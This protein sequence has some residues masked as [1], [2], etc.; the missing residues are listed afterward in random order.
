MIQQEKLLER[1]KTLPN[2]L[3]IVGQKYSGKKT[4]LKE[5]APDFYW[6][7]GKVDAIRTLLDGDYVFADVDD[8]SPACFS[9][10]LKMLEE[11]TDHI[12]ITCK[13][14]MNLPRSIQSR[15]IIERMEPYT[16]LGHYCDTI[17]QLEFATDELIKSVD[18]YEYKEEYDLDVYFSVLCNRLL[19]RIK[20]GEDVTK[21]Y[22]I[23]SKFNSAKNLK[24]LNKKQFITNWQF[25]I[26]GIS[27]EWMRL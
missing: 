25:C 20:N 22:L 16:G 18:K 26:K 6:A 11:N 10:M 1:L 14:I 3:I 21:E 23:S 8:W 19:E 15:C 4:L 2:N 27:D 9:A 5:I 24:A 12:I 13:N 17:G 7:E